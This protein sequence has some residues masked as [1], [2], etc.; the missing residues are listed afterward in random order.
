VFNDDFHA[1]F[2]LFSGVL[3]R[4]VGSHAPLSLLAM[5]TLTPA[6]TAEKDPLLHTLPSLGTLQPHDICGYVGGARRKLGTSILDYG[7]QWLTATTSTKLQRIA[8]FDT[9]S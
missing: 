8:I 9:T 6:D 4:I 1:N 5:S 2:A 7:F 3:S